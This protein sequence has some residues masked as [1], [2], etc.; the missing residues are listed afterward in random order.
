MLRTRWNV[1]LPHGQ[2]VGVNLRFLLAASEVDRVPGHQDGL[3][4]AV[5]LKTK[6]VGAEP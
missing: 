4:K 6:G 1:S 2:V 5:W 3:L